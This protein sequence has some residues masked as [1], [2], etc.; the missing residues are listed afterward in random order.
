[1]FP[2]RI[3]KISYSDLRFAMQC[4]FLYTNEL[5]IIFWNNEK[6]ALFLRCIHEGEGSFWRFAG[7]FFYFF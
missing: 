2:S 1:M 6:L 7:I 5:L 4:I 3:M